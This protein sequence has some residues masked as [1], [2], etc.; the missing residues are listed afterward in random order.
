MEKIQSTEVPKISLYALTGESEPQ[1]IR[2]RGQ[3]AG[4]V[5]SVLIDSGSKHNFVQM[6]VARR[7]KLP[8]FPVRRC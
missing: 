8:V 4:S 3:V 2:V 1:T 6:A 5:L 7:L